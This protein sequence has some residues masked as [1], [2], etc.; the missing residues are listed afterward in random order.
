MIVE[1][2]LGE[3]NEENACLRMLSNLGHVEVLLHP[4]L[5]YC[6]GRNCSSQVCCLLDLLRCFCNGKLYKPGN[7]AKIADMAKTATTTTGGWCDTLDMCLDKSH[8]GLHAALWH[9]SP[10]C[11]SSQGAERQRRSAEAEDPAV[12]KSSSPSL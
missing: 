4:C 5:Q 2:A 9:P 7:A 11:V 12:I 6:K 10:R 3:K 8:R 1:A